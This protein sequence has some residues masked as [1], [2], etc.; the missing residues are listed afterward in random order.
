RESPLQAG[1][2]IPAG[3]SS[4]PDFHP[5]RI[6]IPAGFSSPPDFHPRRIFIPA[7]G[8]IAGVHKPPG[9]KTPG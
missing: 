8:L 3:F 1:I 7:G 6:F 9:V 4:P 2:F 5:R